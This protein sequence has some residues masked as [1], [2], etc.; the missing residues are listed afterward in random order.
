M[1]SSKRISAAVAVCI[2]FCLAFSGF[3]VYGANTFD[4][5][6]APEYQEKL[7]G[8]EILTIDIQTAEEDWQGLL[9]NAQAKEWIS[10][11]LVINGETFT[12]VGVRT[13]GNSSLSMGNR[14]S[15]G[16]DSEAARY[17]LQF[18]FNKYVKGQTCYGL[19]AFCINNMMGD[20]TYMKDYI[21]YDIMNYAGVDT[22][23]V[24]YASVTVNG[25]DYGFFVAL[26][27]YDK[28][29]LDRVYDTAGGQ[30]YSVKISMGRRG[31]FEDMFEDAPEGF[32][33]MRQRVFPGLPGNQQ[34]GVATEAETDIMQP[35]EGQNFSNMQPPEGQ[36]FSNMQPPEGQ[37][38]SNMQ[39]PEG[40]NFS[41]MQ[42]PEGQNI[43]NMQPPE[44]IDF[45]NMQ[46]PEGMDFSNMQPPEGMDF[47]NMQPPEGINA[48]ETLPSDDI[49]A[50][51]TQ[52]LGGM[53]L[54]AAEPSAGAGLTE[55]QANDRMVGGMGF[56]GFGGSGGGSLLYTDGEISSYSSIFDNA[57]FG[58]NSDKDKQRVITAIKNLNEGTDL[59]EYFDVDQ[60]LRYF[61]AH[62]FVVNLD[63]YISNMQQNYYIYEREG[64]LTV[65]PWDYGLAFGGYQ[66]GNASSVV[67]F[68][69]D[70]PVS[71]VS[72]E[73]RPLLNKL[74]EV[75]EYFEKYHEYLSQIANGYFESGLFESTVNALDAKI[76]EYVKS[77]ATA[78]F[79]YEQY[80]AAL[81]EFV[82]LGM[83]R[84]E[85]VNGQLDGT[86]PSTTAGQNAD[87]SALVDS[88][89]VDLSAMGS[90]MG[91]GGMGGN[92][93]G[94][95]A[96][97]EN[98][99]P[100]GLGMMGMNGLEGIDM[101]IAQQAIPIL[102]ESGG[103]LT[104]DVKSRLTALG[105]TEEQ[106]TS[107]SDMQ[108]F[109]P[110]GFGGEE[111]IDFGGMPG[112]EADGQASVQTL[113]SNDYLIILG[114]LIIL[115]ISAIIF[116]A[117]PGKN[118]I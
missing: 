63:S 34:G 11:D 62:T 54:T 81:E 83:L 44:G 96:P 1:I 68:P 55:G 59:E 71:G 27:R 49:E 30:L 47:S 28:S 14:G 41:N 114:V 3:I 38:F 108:G 115:L 106:I 77:D 40:K 82:E 118:T 66:S 76:G 26:E 33:D 12:T 99:G 15:Q 45:S 61:A 39:P 9:D 16:A 37:N 22:P 117:R 20:A 100:G 88:S 53:D 50:D 25:K 18:K 95:E 21:S 102:M 46:P 110:G 84:A 48:T 79:T 56:G 92:R 10:A 103:E 94:Q 98:G 8:E 87:S 80:Q 69:I 65:L 105:V 72:L 91:G 116:I 90:M 70:T 109:I 7:F 19:D 73:D 97:G 35:P 60:I 23:L 111:G 93:D 112:W 67:N 58:G 17:S 32:G 2:A 78:Y 89:G 74:L 4:T 36:N 75:P 24:N 43:S 51:D 101:N 42:P 107:F 6:S 13:K 57:V 64:K 86:I 31:D 104:E 113:G 29:F 52:S 85:S 5:S